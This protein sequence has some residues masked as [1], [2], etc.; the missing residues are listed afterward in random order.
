MAELKRVVALSNNYEEPCQHMREAYDHDIELHG[1][2]RNLDEALSLIRR[3]ADD[4]RG[5]T[6][7]RAPGFVLL[8]QPCLRFRLNL[9]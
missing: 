4:E 5:K 2:R 3:V 7:R 1:G 6:K 9:A 8:L